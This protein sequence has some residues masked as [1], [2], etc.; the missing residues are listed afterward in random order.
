VKQPSI[1]LKMKV[2]GAIDIAPGKTRHERVQ[3]V[4]AMTFQ[5]EEGNPYQFT[6]RTI[7]TWHYRYKN[8]GVT[9]METSLR[10]DKGKPRKVTPE[11]VLEAINQALPH[12]HPKSKEYAASCVTRQ[13]VMQRRRERSNASFAGFVINF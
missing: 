6:W 4:A 7:Q 11:E 5:D 8:H 10:A 9:G 3:N 12:F 13:S 1:Y 2:L